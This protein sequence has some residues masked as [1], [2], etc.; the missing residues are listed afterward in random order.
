[1]KNID[2]VAK[3]DAVRGGQEKEKR[4]NL[5][6]RYQTAQEE[7]EYLKVLFYGMPFYREHGYKVIL[8]TQKIFQDLLNENVSLDEVNWEEVKQ[9]FVKYEYDKNF[10]KLGIDA[11]EKYRIEIES[12]F[13]VFLILHKLWNFRIYSS[14]EIALTKYGPGGRYNHNLGRMLLMV[15]KDGSFKRF[16]PLH[17]VIHEMVHF[18]IEEVI[19]KKLALSHWEKECLVDLICKYKFDHIIP[20][21]KMQEKRDK[22]LEKYVTSEKIDDLPSVIE[23]YIVDYPRT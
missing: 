15:R 23:Q 19:V 3:N 4:L 18:G 20:D 6:I 8:P 2:I 22:R 11:L 1:M 7:L 17:T 14:Y 10:F 9:F 21:Y 12:V 13:K 5:I 16:N